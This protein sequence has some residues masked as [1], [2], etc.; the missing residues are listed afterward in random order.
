MSRLF[1]TPNTRPVPIHLTEAKAHTEAQ[2]LADATLCTWAVWHCRRHE[3]GAYSH[4]EAYHVKPDG[5]AFPSACGCWKL[6]PAHR[7][8]R[9]GA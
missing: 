5:Y 7:P 2:R 3:D 1:P 9:P 6:Y 4:P 8:L